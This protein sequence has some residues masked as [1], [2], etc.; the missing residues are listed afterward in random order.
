M[1]YYF[2][3]SF[4]GNGNLVSGWRDGRERFYIVVPHKHRI[5]ERYNRAP[6][7]FKDLMFG[8]G[9]LHLKDRDTTGFPTPADRE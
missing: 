2:R 1:R 4:D 5:I 3:V 8:V 9:V 7:I 6:Q